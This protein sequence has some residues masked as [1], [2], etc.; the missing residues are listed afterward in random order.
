[1]RI[2]AAAILP[3]GF[4]ALVLALLGQA[5]V[6]GQAA[7]QIEVLEPKPAFDTFPT[8]QFLTISGQRAAVGFLPG[9][10]D[11]ADHVLR[12]LDNLTAFFRR[13]SPELP[14]PMSAYLV[15]RAH[16]KEIGLPGLYGLPLRTS[17]SSVFV[18]AGGDEELVR[19]WRS[20]LGLD[21]LPMVPGVP[22]VGTP[23]EA[24]SLAL[25]DVLM[26][27]E[28]ARGYAVAARLQG[29]A[30]WVQEAAAHVAALVA[31]RQTEPQRTD[32]LRDFF[33]RLRSRMG[34]PK[35]YDAEHF[36]QALQRGQEE[37]IKAWLWY[38]GVFFAAAEVI[39]KKD[40]KRAIQRLL[41][42]R[43]ANGRS[44]SDAALLKRY[45]GLRDWHSEWFSTPSGEFGLSSAGN[46]RSSASTHQE[47][48]VPALAL[49]P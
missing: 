6:Y 40:G 44:L 29:R 32:E 48:L 23:E 13:W 10:L 8:P 25:A 35:R 26:Q 22:V 24:A 46:P 30:G 42:L 12:R 21:I 47:V 17:P 4:L 39:V 3:A 31:F 36:S 14:V 37:E 16:W 34:G 20:A 2:F 27:T 43:A 41:K 1:M 33:A 11:R 45:P 38:Q 49:T 28:A 19:M 18:P 7:A 15:D 5:L 9:G